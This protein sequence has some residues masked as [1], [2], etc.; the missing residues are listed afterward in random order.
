MQ[1]LQLESVTAR[2]P[3]RE[4]LKSCWVMRSSAEELQSVP[5]LLIPG[6]CPEVSRNC[7]TKHT[8]PYLKSGR[9]IAPMLW[10]L[11][12]E[13][14]LFFTLNLEPFI[15]RTKENLCHPK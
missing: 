3:L 7:K 14:L 9:S 4:A 2:A 12:L 15:Y 13:S 10:L 1:K 11:M 5:D 8:C 6:G